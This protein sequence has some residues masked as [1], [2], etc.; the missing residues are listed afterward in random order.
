[1]NDR[2][3]NKKRQRSPNQDNLLD[4]TFY[5]VSY[6]FLIYFQDCISS[7][8]IYNKDETDNE[9]DDNDDI[10]YFHNSKDKNLKQVLFDSKTNDWEL[11]KYEEYYDPELS[12]ATDTEK[13][14][15]YQIKKEKNNVT[16][17]NSISNKGQN[18]SKENK[19][20]N[21]SH[22]FSPPI[23]ESTQNHYPYTINEIINGKYKV[24]Y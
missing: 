15:N 8:A 11:K 24:S 5:K 21:S 7:K 23:S 20:N 6:F 16:S 14:G 9:N 12:M 22:S 13:E 18:N 17:E 1:M 2:L 19:S 3:C 4:I 10:M